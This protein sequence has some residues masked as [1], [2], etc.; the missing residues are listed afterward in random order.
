MSQAGI[1]PVW[2]IERDPAIAAVAQ[3]N[4]E[5]KII[6]ADI[7]S[8]DPANLE[9]VDLLHA[10][11][12][13]PNFSNA[14]QDAVETENDI[15]LARKVAEFVKVQ[16]PRFFTLE[17]VPRYRKSDSWLKI[18]QP[19]LYEAGYMVHAALLNSADFGV[20]QTRRRFIVRAVR[21]GFVPWLPQAEPWPG[22][23][24]AIEDLIS[25][26]P[27]SQFANWQWALMPEELK[28]MVI[29]NGC[30]EKLVSR[31]ASE[32]IFTLTAN[33]NQAEIKAFIINS[34]NMN[35][36]LTVR[37]EN[38]P[39]FTIVSNMLAKN[40]PP[41]AFIVGGQYQTANN[42]IRRIPQN[43]LSDEPIW[44]ITASEHG[45]TRVWLE[46]GRV[47]ALN[48][49]AL[50]R[51]QSFPDWYRLPD[52]RI[53]ACKGIGNAVPPMWYQKLAEGLTR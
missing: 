23:F 39:M 7:L 41:K 16:R 22:W 14:K 30:Y 8:V 40:S 17:N 29:A 50:A 51:L 31:L 20:P 12:P 25:E 36:S 24:Q 33:S 26:L 18:I 9:A 35:S 44:T 6:V 2:S 38:E 27:D 4:F 32:P 28:T 15:A 42:A 11:P 13:C 49:R 5:H 45:D 43:R 47:V 21:G 48:T 1:E 52:N 53:L 19:A 3:A 10:S 46:T 34:Q 37:G